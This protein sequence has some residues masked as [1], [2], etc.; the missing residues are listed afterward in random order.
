[1]KGTKNLKYHNKICST[2]SLFT[3]TYYFCSVDLRVINC[4]HSHKHIHTL[5][6]STI[7]VWKLKCKRDLF[8]VFIVY[9]D[10]TTGDSST[11]C[12]NRHTSPHFTYTDS[13][14]VL[15]MHDNT[16]LINLKLLC[17]SS[18]SI[19]YSF[20]IFLLLLKEKNW[21]NKNNNKLND[22]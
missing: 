13:V 18:R 21:R 4:R 2:L 12:R 10:R 7:R 22:I 20:N 5:S 16:L 9:G 19:R 17:T 8:K 1:M 15:K 3:E 11:M 14:T 6:L